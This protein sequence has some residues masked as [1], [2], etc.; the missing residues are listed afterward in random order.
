MSQA[1]HGSRWPGDTGLE[2]GLQAPMVLVLVRPRLLTGPSSPGSGRASGPDSAPSGGGLGPV[3]GWGRMGL[4]L[5]VRASGSLLPAEGSAGG[6]GG[7][8]VKVRSDGR[9]GLEP[10]SGDTA[11]RSDKS[12]GRKYESKKTLSEN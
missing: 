2:A 10:S 8:G 5:R 4:S 11:S 12:E 3:G 9:D 7:D 1:Y 6:R